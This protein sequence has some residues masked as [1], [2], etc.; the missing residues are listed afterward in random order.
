V[1]VFIIYWLSVV[2]E[3]IDMAIDPEEQLR[4]VEIGADH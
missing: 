3:L 2:F 4:M 1:K